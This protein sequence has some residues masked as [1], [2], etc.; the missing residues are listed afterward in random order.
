MRKLR[1]RTGTPARLVTLG[2]GLL[3]AGLVVGCSD[4][5]RAR[6]PGPAAVADPQA[7]R[8]EFAFE[9]RIVFQSDMDGDNEICLLTADGVRKLT[10]NA[11]NDEFPKWSPDGSKIAFMANPNGPYIL[12]VMNAD[13]SGL[14]PLGPRED[15]T[16]SRGGFAGLDWS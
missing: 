8:P 11:W 5:E 15:R 10:D 2:V 1:R 12:F 4:R 7:L 9:G 16:R 13:G 3:L 6:N 14:A